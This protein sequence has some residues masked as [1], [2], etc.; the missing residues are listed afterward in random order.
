MLLPEQTRSCDCYH[1]P[2]EQASFEIGRSS[3]RAAQ[4]E[5]PALFPVSARRSWEKMLRT[6]V[7]SAVFVFLDVCA[8]PLKRQTHCE[9]LRGP[10]IPDWLP[11]FFHFPLAGNTLKLP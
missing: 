3:I 2:R 5:A 10:G 7:F 1:S 9:G 4:G 6:N 11:F 8:F